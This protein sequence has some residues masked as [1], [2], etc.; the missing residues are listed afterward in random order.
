[1]GRELLLTDLK[2]HLR[3]QKVGVINQVSA[4]GL[5]GI[6]KTALAIEYSWKH[7]SDYKLIWFLRAGAQT[8]LLQDYVRLGMHLDVPEGLN[9]EDLIRQVKTKLGEKKD[10]LLVVDNARDAKSINDYLPRGGHIIVTSRNKNCWKGRP[11]ELPVFGD[12]DVIDYVNEVCGYGHEHQEKDIKALGQLLGYLPLAVSQAMSCIRNQHMSILAYIKMFKGSRKRLLNKEGQLTDHETVYITVTACLDKIAVEDAVEVMKLCACM[13]ADQI[14]DYL[15]KK[16]LE[17]MLKKRKEPSEEQNGEERK[18]T[19]HNSVEE[20]FDDVITALLEYSLIH[21]MA[22]S[23]SV[24]RLVQVVI[25]ERQTKVERRKW[26]TEAL[27]LVDRELNF[28][29]L[30]MD[31]KAWISSRNLVAHVQTVCRAAEK[32]RLEL[33]TVGYLYHKLGT[34]LFAAQGQHDEALYYYRLNLEIFKEVHQTES[35]ESVGATLDAIGWMLYRAGQYDE[36]L[37]YFQ[38]CLKIYKEVYQTDKQANVAI[39]LDHVGW[40]FEAKGFYTEALNCF[41]RSLDIFKKVHQSEN[42]PHVA[43]AFK[44]IG[45]VFLSKGCYSKALDYFQRCLDIQIEVYLTERHAEVANTFN[46][47]GL[48]LQAMGK[49]DEALERFQL[50][51]DIQKEVY[52]NESNVIVAST[53]NNIGLVLKAK[54]QYDE[55]LDHFRLCLKIKKSVYQ[56]EQCAEVAVTI[57]NIGCVLQDKGLYGEAEVMLGNAL[58]IYKTVLPSDHPQIRGC[59]E[60]LRIVKDLDD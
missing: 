34:Y 3:Q 39:A 28:D 33:E 42:H 21:K 19:I 9:K 38:R 47:I 7:A 32:E 23:I 50:C 11:F 8:S 15:V 60:L 1:M 59:E 44:S 57:F 40:V 4:I 16:W 25:T 51:L 29:F 27:E 22:E 56:T 30:Y 37:V 6:G 35:H 58:R 36:A 52:H 41:Q 43:N 10:W 45:G 5:G 12:K 48:L 2:R 54:A 24:H 20:L 53:Y 55:A 49:N 14:P 26:V 46:N 17:E 18:T 31:M 13:A